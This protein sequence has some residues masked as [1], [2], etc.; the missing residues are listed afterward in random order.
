VK[1]PKGMTELDI[2]ARTRTMLLSSARCLGERGFALL[3]QRWKTLQN[4][5]TRQS[6][7]CGL[8]QPERA[9]RVSGVMAVGGG[10][11]GMPVQAQ[12]ADGQATR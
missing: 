6:R 9:L 12:Q 11:V 8:K 2:N 3:S 5:G 4:A 1:K 10:D 7:S